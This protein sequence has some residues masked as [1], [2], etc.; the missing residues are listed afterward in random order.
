MGVRGGYLC[1][2][3][4]DGSALC[5][6]LAGERAPCLNFLLL[7]LFLKF[8]SNRPLAERIPEMDP[9]LGARVSGAELGATVTGAEV[10]GTGKWPARGSAPVTLAPSSAP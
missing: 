6:V 7:V 2:A 4:E 1:G 10:L 8:L 5:S 9:W 3:E